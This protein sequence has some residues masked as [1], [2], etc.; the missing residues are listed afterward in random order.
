L[1]TPI[2]VPT[3]L[4]EAAYAICFRRGLYKVG[5]VKQVEK[6]QISF[7][8]RAV[9]S[10]LVSEQQELRQYRPTKAQSSANAAVNGPQGRMEAIGLL[11]QVSK[12]IVAAVRTAT[13][14]ITS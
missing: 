2:E 3:G 14:P 6:E 13:N 8:N 5:N 4:Q 10:S 7:E 9:Y 1:F 12:K 11:I